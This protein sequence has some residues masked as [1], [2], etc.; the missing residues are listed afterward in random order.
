M[1]AP[2]S[3]H[4]RSSTPLKAPCSCPPESP[5]TPASRSIPKHGSFSVVYD[6]YTRWQV[7][8]INYASIND[9][10][11]WIGEFLLTDERGMLLHPEP[12]GPRICAVTPHVSQKKFV[13]MQYQRGRCKLG[14]NRCSYI[15]APRCHV[16]WLRQLF[17]EQMET[18]VHPAVQQAPLG[19]V[20][21][22]LDKD[23]KLYVPWSC[24]HTVN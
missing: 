24:I 12:R 6:P 15:H 17:H 3:P 19:L 4:H 18:G 11:E 2:P 21:E 16:A 5:S 1:A 9:G 23:H 8:Q 22:V 10:R 7:G 14:S 13:C 20:V